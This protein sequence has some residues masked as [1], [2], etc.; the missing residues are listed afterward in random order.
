MFHPLVRRLCTV[1]FTMTI[2]FAV[3][4]GAQLLTWREVLDRPNRPQPDLKIAYGTDANQYGELWLPKGA[5]TKAPYP[6]VLMIHGGCWLAELPGPELLAFQ[7]DALREAGVAVWS[8][9]YRRLGHK[10]GENGGGGYPGTFLDAGNGADKLFELAQ[11]YPLDLTHVVATGHSAGGHL[12]LWIA[13]RPNIASGS[14][15]KVN[16]PLPISA[17]VGVAAVPDLAY[18]SSAIAH[19]CGTGTIDALV[20]LKSRGATGDSDGAWKDTSPLALLPLRVRQTLV[21]GAQD[22]IVPAANADRYKSRAAA[23]GEA[24]EVIK[25]DNAG[26]F[27]LIS[28]WTPAGREVVDIILRAT[29]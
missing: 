26:H 12:A 18:S 29:R 28:P 6:V 20:D 15:L 9:S 1:V 25:L 8:I 23:L 3:D 13:G 7:A 21:F 4:A 24:V 16:K 14:A 17:V 11:K 22:P 19:A 10:G 2:L 5:N 27:E